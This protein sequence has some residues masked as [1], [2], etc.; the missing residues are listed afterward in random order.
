MKPYTL[1]KYELRQQKELARLLVEVSAKLK[2]V[3]IG[4]YLEE[5]YRIDRVKQKLLINV[6]MYLEEGDDYN[7][8][9]GLDRLESVGI[10]LFKGI[11]L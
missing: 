3:K 9:I 2:G 7:Y 6:L 4:A 10:E 11:I 5:E 1:S 8:T